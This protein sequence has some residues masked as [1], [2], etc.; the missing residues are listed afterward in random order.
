MRG[1][2]RSEGIIRSFIRRFASCV[3]GVKPE[4]VHS[5]HM[6]FV[7]VGQENAA[8]IE[9]FYEDRGAGE[10]V[11]LVHGYPLAGNS[12]ERQAASLLDEGHRVVTYDRRGSG[13]SS[14]PTCGYDWETLANDLHL[15][16]TRLELHQASLVAHSLGTGDAMRYLQTYGSKR[17]SRLALVAPLG[18]YPSA[19]E[20]SRVVPEVDGTRDNGDRF[21]ELVRIVADYYNADELLGVRVS[22]EVLQH[23]WSVAADGS[24]QA[25]SIFSRA[26]L[27]EFNEDLNKLGIPL[28]VILAGK[29]RILGGA[30]Y[31]HAYR[32]LRMSRTLLLA[33]APHGLLWTHAREVNEA[34][35]EFIDR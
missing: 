1:D 27:G 9:L 7:T 17:V 31:E 22:A 30:R 11:V 23:S 20:A 35:L 28:L 5:R 21:S 10:P 25:A 4:R 13:R 18:P 8:S 2:A 33:D 16:M 32:A 19:F 24:P 15:L 14:R 3:A 6:A 12:W 29:D 34:L 26:L